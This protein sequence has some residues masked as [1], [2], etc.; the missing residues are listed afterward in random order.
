V[1]GMPLFVQDA[2]ILGSQEVSGMLVVRRH[3]LENQGLLEPLRLVVRAKRGPFAGVVRFG[4][5]AVNAI[6]KAA[7]ANPSGVQVCGI[8]QRVTQHV[9][10]GIWIA[11]TNGLYLPNRQQNN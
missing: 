7:K 10:H 4:R 6:L 5:D 8:P 9:A 3:S 2:R 11:D 1:C